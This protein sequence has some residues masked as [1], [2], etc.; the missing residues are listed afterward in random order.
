LTALEPSGRLVGHLQLH[1]APAEGQLGLVGGLDR[2]LHELGAPEGGGLFALLEPAQLVD[3]V[4]QLVG[5][6]A[7][8]ASVRHRGGLETGP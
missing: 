6:R 2:E 8:L 4:E 1:L 5:G 3:Y 7:K